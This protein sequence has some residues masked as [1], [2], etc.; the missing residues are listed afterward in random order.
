MENK[1]QENS[2]ACIKCG[3]YQSEESGAFEGFICELCN[4]P[5]ANAESLEKYLDS[6]VSL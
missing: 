6:D 1:I 2:F 3:L 4:T 5:F